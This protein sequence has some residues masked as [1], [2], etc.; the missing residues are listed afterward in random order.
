MSAVLTQVVKAWMDLGV[1]LVVPVFIFILGIFFKMKPGRAFRSAV[2][3][4]VSFTGVYLALNLLLDNIGPAA[5]AAV[6]RF[7]FKL[8][9]LD[10]G[11]P[12]LA[13]ITFGSRFFVIVFLG[14]LIAN[15]VMLKM[16][17]TKTLDVDFQ[18]YY[19][20]IF[21]AAAVYFVTHNFLLAGLTG[22]LLAVI[23]FKLAD[24]TAPL[25]ED[26]WHIEGISIP[27]LSTVGWAP[28]YYALNWVIDRIPVIRDIDIN[29]EGV[30]EKL[31]VFG[32]PMIFSLIIGGALGIFAG[33]DFSATLNLAINTAAAMTILPKMVGML[34]ESMAPLSEAAREYMQDR[35]SDGKFYI[36]LDVAVLIGDPSVITTGLLLIPITIILAV[37]LPGNKTLPFSDLGA[38]PVY[39]VWALAMSHGN[40]FRGVL[41]GTVCMAG[42]LLIATY[43]APIFTDL[44]NTVGFVS[45][46]PGQAITC[47]EGGQQIVSYVIVQIISLLKSIF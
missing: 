7:G 35:F 16:R 10:V 33:Y 6:T 43:F 32:E 45:P 29:P 1:V 22:I 23:T 3:F 9:I 27:H 47:L 17:W 14:G 42:V 39:I 19:H 46:V 13:S 15:M 2:L 38:L 21:G 31:G 26:Y 5:Q 4:A 8:E 36:G 34:M 28:V 24:W 12:V 20:W 37:I 41:M 44:A 18:N 25:V 11:W 30:E 40:I